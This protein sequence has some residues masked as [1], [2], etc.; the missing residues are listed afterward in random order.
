VNAALT[1]VGIIGGVLTIFGAA[2]AI[3]RNIV[4]NVS[5]TEDNTKATKNNTDAIAEL[6]HKVEQLGGKVDGVYLRQAIQGDRLS[7]IERKMT[8][9]GKS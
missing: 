5:A 4:K 3:I 7:L 9:N 2:F 6:T 8:Q 1:V